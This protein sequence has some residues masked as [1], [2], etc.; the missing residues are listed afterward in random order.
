M[1]TKSNIVS[2]ITNKCSGSYTAWRIG[3]THD[4]VERKK[5]WG[6]TQKQD[7]KLWADW[8]ADSLKDAQD[9]ESYF[10]NDK[11]MKGGTGGDLSSRS[12]VYVY[13]F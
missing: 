6:E 7:V 3:L 5:Y 13:V 1:T 2:A 10:I 12:T 4:L 8:T 11:K 9:I